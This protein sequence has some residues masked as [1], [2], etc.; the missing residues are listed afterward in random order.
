M[1]KKTVATV[2]NKNGEQVIIRKKH[3]FKPGT[4]ATLEIRKYMSGKKAVVKCIPKTRIEKLIREIVQNEN[5][6]PD[7]LSQGA[8]DALWEGIKPYYIFIYLFYIVSTS[9]FITCFFDRR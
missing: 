9:I 2:T 5:L 4:R 8:I 6:G 1:A 3:R 7:R